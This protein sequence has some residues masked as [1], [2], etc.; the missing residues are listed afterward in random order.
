MW[1]GDRHQ[2]KAL[3]EPPKLIL[4]GELR[5]RISF[6]KIS[7]LKAVGDYLAFSVD[8]HSVRLQLGSTMAQ[9][10]ADVIVKPPS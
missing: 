1:N 5:H 3:L 8:G 2:V 9:K 4:R 10:W 7:S 6:A